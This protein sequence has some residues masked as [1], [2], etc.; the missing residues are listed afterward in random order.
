[1]T[2]RKASILSKGRT[3]GDPPCP[4]TSPFTPAS[5][6]VNE[7]YQRHK[8]ANPWLFGTPLTNL[9]VAARDGAVTGLFVRPIAH[10]Q[11]RL[12]PVPLD[13]DPEWNARI[14]NWAAD[15]G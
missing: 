3:A 7:V 2:M 12:L 11:F 14:V 1:M 13:R 15:R 4:A 6:R 10:G 9:P 5:T 8:T